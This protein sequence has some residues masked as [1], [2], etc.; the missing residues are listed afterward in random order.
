MNALRIVVALAAAMAVV[1]ANEPKVGLELLE[2]KTN[3]S[4]R[5]TSYLYRASFERGQGQDLIYVVLAIHAGTPLIPGPYMTLGYDPK[6]QLT[7]VKYTFPAP[8]AP[9]TSA[10]FE[11]LVDDVWTTGIINWRGVVASSGSGQMRTRIMTVDGPAPFVQPTPAQLEPPSIK[12]NATFRD[13]NRHPDFEH[14]VGDDRGIVAS[15]LGI[16]GTPTY[17]GGVH[18]SVSS[19]STFS[20]WY[21]DVPGVNIRIELPMTAYKVPGS[22]P[23]Q[24]KYDSSY[25]FPIDH[26]GYGNNYLG[27][28]FGF[29]MM[30]STLFTYRGGET[31]YFRGDDD[32]FVFINRQRVIDLGGVHPAEEASVSLD[33]LGLMLN[34]T[35]P[36]NLFFAERH[37]TESSFKMTT[38]LRLQ[39]CALDTCGLRGS[40]AQRPQLGVWRR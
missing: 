29:T 3:C 31:F 11:L 32:V 2:V 16:D 26:M 37:T 10:D 14:Y 24:Y 35:Y 20:Q 36:L 12:W 7:G 33:G 27:H 5:R 21:H 17:A 23:A 8:V 15:T 19:A 39:D 28:N 22:H 18:P 38:T 1:W 25:F 9:G 34:A 6:T 4:W 40:G 30:I 13:F